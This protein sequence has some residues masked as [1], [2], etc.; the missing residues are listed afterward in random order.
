MR[1][2]M[3]GSG[4]GGGPFGGPTRGGGGMGGAGLAGMFGPDA[5]AKLKSNPRIAKYFEDP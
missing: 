5:E 4:M 3:Q 1:E 2:M